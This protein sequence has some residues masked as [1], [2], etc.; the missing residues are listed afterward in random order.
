MVGSDEGE[1]KCLY[2]NEIG[3]GSCLTR[4]LS[5]SREFIL[6]FALV[7]NFLDSDNVLVK[8]NQVHYFK[9]AISHQSDQFV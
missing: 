7:L 9:L 6:D 2:S 1:E 8:S 3:A 4:N 5:K